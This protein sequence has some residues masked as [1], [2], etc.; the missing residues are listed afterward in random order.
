M[1]SRDHGR[2]AHSPDKLTYEK[3]SGGQAAPLDRLKLGPV[4][5]LGWSAGGELASVGPRR[6]TRRRSR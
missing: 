1:D 5:V 4:N 2:S 6:S 3:M